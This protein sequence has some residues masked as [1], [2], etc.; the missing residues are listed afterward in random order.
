VCARWLP[1]PNSRQARQR[2]SR[3]YAMQC[4]GADYAS[5]RHEEV[6]WPVTIWGVVG[7]DQVAVLEPL[8]RERGS[9]CAV[10]SAW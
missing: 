1:N 10:R 8:R 3:R 9:G 4:D 2:G 7:V 6:R 5:L